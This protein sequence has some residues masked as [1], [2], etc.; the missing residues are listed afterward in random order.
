MLSAIKLSI[1]PAGDLRKYYYNAMTFSFPFSA[2]AATHLPAL[3][4][5]S[6]PGD[7]GHAES[8]IGASDVPG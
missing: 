6:L 3:Y 7:L 5:M 8:G 4:R 2:V 1:K